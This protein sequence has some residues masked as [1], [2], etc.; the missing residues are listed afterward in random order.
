[1]AIKGLFAGSV[2]DVP[3]LGLV[4]AGPG[5]ECV[6]IWAQGQRHAIAQV[7]HEDCFLLAR[8][9]V[10]QGTGGRDREVGSGSADGTAVLQT[11]PQP[12]ISEQLQWQRL[13]IARRGA[14]CHHSVRTMLII[15]YQVVSPELVMIS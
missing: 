2:S 10:P 1:M 9:N 3:Q 6:H 14:V 7:V 5:D 4:V 12:H 15:D 11:H 13:S 8:L